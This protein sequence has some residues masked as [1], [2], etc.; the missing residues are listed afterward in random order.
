M[1]QDM[2]IASCRLPRNFLCTGYSFL[3]RRNFSPPPLYTQQTYTFATSKCARISNFHTLEKV[4]PLHQHTH[5]H[6]PTETHS[7][8]H[9][10]THTHRY[11][12]TYRHTHRHT[13]TYTHTHLHT[14][15]PTHTH[16]HTPS[17]THLH[18]HT[19][20]SIQYTFYVSY[21]PLYSSKLQRFQL[22]T[23]RSELI[24]Q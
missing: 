16:L 8:T 19:H 9:T 6:T 12:L 11:T 15:S 22:T 14:H 20:T 18:T 1:F 10:F 21:K 5:L 7:P 2:S 17:H 4:H 23:R 3:Q 24:V 13:L